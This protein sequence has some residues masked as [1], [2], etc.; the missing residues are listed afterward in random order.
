M[1]SSWNE[2]FQVRARIN[3]PGFCVDLK[4]WGNAAQYARLAQTFLLTGSRLRAT[5]QV[6]L[7][8]LRV[9]DGGKVGVGHGLFCGEA[10]LRGTS[11]VSCENRIKV[12]PKK[13]AD[14]YRMIVAQQLVQK[15]DGLIADKTLVL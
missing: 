12:A 5:G 11:L 7:E 14:T 4:I 6:L 10:F 8:G 13:L 1:A 15:V 3:N 2:G 9:A